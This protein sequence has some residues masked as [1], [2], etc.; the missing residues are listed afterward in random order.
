MAFSCIT[1]FSTREKMIFSDLPPLSSKINWQ[2]IYHTLHKSAHTTPFHHLPQLTR[3]TPSR[4]APSQYYA[5]A[6]EGPPRATPPQALTTGQPRCAWEIAHWAENI[7]IR[8]STHLPHFREKTSHTA[9]SKYKEWRSCKNCRMYYCG[10][11]PI[12]G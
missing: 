4:T 8:H 3:T 10:A 7:K 12:K 6:K 2:V 9:F 5:K 11:S 1:P